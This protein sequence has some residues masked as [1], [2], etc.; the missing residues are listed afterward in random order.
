[1]ASRSVD[2][3]PAGLPRH[4]T[5]PETNLWFNVEVSAARYPDKP[6]IVFYDTPLTYA[7]FKAQ[8]EHIAGWLQHDCGVRAGDRVLL[9]MQNSPQWVLAHYAILRANAVVVPVNPMNRTD[10]L[11]HYVSDSGAAVAFVP[12]DLYD[13][14]RPL[15]HG[16]EGLRHVIVATYADYLEVATD[17]P[18]PAFVA[19]PR[20]AIDDPGVTSWQRMLDA[21]RVPG[22]LTAG[23]DDLCVMPYT[24]GTTGRPKG[25][26]HTHR[27]AMATLVGGVQWFARTQDA[28][29]LSAMP[30]FHVTG[31]VGGMNG[32]LYAGATIV[33]LPRWDRDAA[34]ACM[35]RHRVTVWSAI[36]TMLI[37]FLSNPRL[38]EL[39]LS[40][41]QVIRGGGA[42]M[43][44]AVVAALHTA[45]GLPYVEGYGMSETLAA[46]HLNPPQRAKPQ[47][48]GIPMFDVDARVVDPLTLAQV[49]PGETGEIIVAAPQVML[50]YWRDEAATRDAF[51][52]RDG[53]RFLRTGDLAMI[54]E[55]GYFFMV[56]RLKRMI[57][58]SG[59]KV[60]PAEVESL[61]YRHPAILEAC[62][63][64][65]PD[66]RRGETVKALVV[67]RAGQAGQVSE[68]DVIDWS[69]EHMAAYK[70][71]RIVE[72]V[73]SLPK[74][75][76]GKVQW[77]ELQER[78]RTSAAPTSPTPTSS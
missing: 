54:D 41:L 22:T 11:R 33:V 58:A 69:R 16:A 71:P 28:V 61:M 32:P 62:V 31:L 73:A 72:F 21:Q 42:A 6:F 40:S 9:Y 48:L 68:Q 67:L 55:D 30:F 14:V 1:M 19:A 37:D 35:Q 53:K 36:S 76:A 77:R 5:L 7:Q 43:P 66:A 51:L 78:E 45:T 65:A 59:F 46:T 8:A 10:E 12:Q 75:G 44:A 47:C 26:M 50:G 17:L 25:C 60:W 29:F 18:L 70:C 63:I 56:D 52:E 39:D 4:L 74:S 27:G 38:P 64:A 13:E 23:P 20:R 34:A 2:S 15:L 24:S 49:L 3:W 57:N